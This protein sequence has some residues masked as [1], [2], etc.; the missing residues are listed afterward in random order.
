MFGRAVVVLLCFPVAILVKYCDR[1]AKTAFGGSVGGKKAGYP[2]RLSV[3]LVR[4]IIGSASSIYV[5]N[6]LSNA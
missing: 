5:R 4:T 3:T 2:I 6:P 1:E